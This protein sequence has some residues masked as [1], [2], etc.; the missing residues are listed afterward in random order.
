[1]K[2]K[3]KLEKPREHNDVVAVLASGPSL[4]W[5]DYA[6]V[7][8]IESL[9]I[10]TI[11]VNSTWRCVRFCD[12]IYAGDTCW[13]R[14]EAGKIDIEAERWTC[15][16]SAMRLYGCQYRDRK[17]KPGYNSGAN[18]V[19]VAANVYGAKAVIMLGFDC[20]IKHGSHHHGNHKKTPNP[21]ADRMPQWKKQFKSLLSVCEN[22]RLINCSR[23]TEIDFI[24][25]MDL[26]KAVEM[27]F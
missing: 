4:G 14:Y 13:W 27:L 3:E 10:K 2:H 16:K 6:D 12:V 9:K 15:A 8:L 20:S 22:S 18:A 25:R 21:N 7:K 1:M 26:K 11:A 5:D 19:E 24:E 23:Y 17:V